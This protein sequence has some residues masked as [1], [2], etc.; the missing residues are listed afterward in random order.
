MS[1]VPFVT[2]IGL[3]EVAKNCTKLTSLNISNTKLITKGS[4]LE[5]IF[6]SCPNLRAVNIEG[7]F[8]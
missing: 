8:A 7:A 4:G 5:A 6:L 3:A 2:D 1:R